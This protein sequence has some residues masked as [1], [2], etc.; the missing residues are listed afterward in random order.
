MSI[1]FMTLLL[2]R[3]RV[4]IIMIKRKSGR[5]CHEQRPELHDLF[6]VKTVE[7][8]HGGKSS[9]QIK[10][11]NQNGWEMFECRENVFTSYA[12]CWDHIY[13]GNVPVS[14]LQYLSRR[15]KAISGIVI[16]VSYVVSPFLGPR[17]IRFP[18]NEGEI[19]EL[20][21][22]YLEAHVFSQRIGTIDGTHI[23]IAEPNEH[24]SDLINRKAYL[25]L[26]VQA[27]CDYKY[28]FEDLVVS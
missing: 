25:S 11:L 16:R 7:S 20:T 22:R 4:A 28:R 14:R 19:K 18:T 3:T 8:M 27:V 23:E 24:Y 13:R 1:F 2:L 5:N 9:L 6:R 15:K 17:L 21:E 10:F 26:N 12:M